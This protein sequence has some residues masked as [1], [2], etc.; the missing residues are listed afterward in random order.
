MPGAPFLPFV[1]RSGVVD[2]ALALDHAVVFVL[3][4]RLSFR[5]TRG[6][7]ARL[8]SPAR[9]QRSVQPEP[10]IHPPL[11]FWFRQLMKNS[12]VLR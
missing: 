2:L 11:H 4:L 12:K 3:A 5:A 7:P 6:I 8:K 1:G 9:L 10:P